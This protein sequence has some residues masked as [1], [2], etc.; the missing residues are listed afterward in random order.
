MKGAGSIAVIDL[1]QTGALFWPPPCY[2]NRRVFEPGALVELTV[3][4]GGERFDRTG[5]VGQGE[6]YSGSGLL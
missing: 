4:S 5:V 2:R 3:R 6:P 1:A